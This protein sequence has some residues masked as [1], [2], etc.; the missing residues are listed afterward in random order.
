MCRYPIESEGE[1]VSMRLKFRT[2]IR[3]VY[4]AVRISVH[5]R[6]S[7][8]PPFTCAPIQACGWRVRGVKVWADDCVGAGVCYCMRRNE[9]G[10]YIRS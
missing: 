3:E 1:R 2:G 4:L 5:T 8:M 7:L 6:L 9:G 10:S